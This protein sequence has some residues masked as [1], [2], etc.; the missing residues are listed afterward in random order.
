MSADRADFF[1][2]S[3]IPVH[4]L[5]QSSLVLAKLPLVGSRV[6]A[7]RDFVCRWWIFCESFAGCVN[8][9]LQICSLGRQVDELS[10]SRAPDSG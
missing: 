9:S 8:A 2:S 6:R 7:L 1:V 5:T 4:L 10:R 3:L